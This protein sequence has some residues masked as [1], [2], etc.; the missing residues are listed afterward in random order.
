ML[1]ITTQRFRVP[2]MWTVPDKEGRS[3]ADE[4]IALMQRCLALLNAGSIKVRLA[5]RESIGLEWLNFFKARGIPF[6]IRVKAGM[7]VITEDG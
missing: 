7:I 2:L 4:C 6:A 1:A 5:D 3:K